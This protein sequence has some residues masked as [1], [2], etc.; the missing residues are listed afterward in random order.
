MHK[1]YFFIASFEKSC[2]CIIFTVAFLT[3]ALTRN[4]T[5]VRSSMA[6]VHVCSVR[7]RLATPTRCVWSAACCRTAAC[8]NSHKTACYNSI[9]LDK[10]MSSAGL[11]LVARSATLQILS[12]LE[13]LPLWCLQTL[14]SGK[15]IPR[16]GIVSSAVIDL[17]HLCYSEGSAQLQTRDWLLLLWG[18]MGPC[19]KEGDLF[20]HEEHYF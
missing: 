15:S 6:V 8:K 9:Y 11:F 18:N 4:S 3:P 13:Y 14:C 1:C 7:C 12:A 10:L 2:I 16:N 5:G 19:S 17:G 20:Y